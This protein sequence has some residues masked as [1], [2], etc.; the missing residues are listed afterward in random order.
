MDKNPPQLDSFQCVSTAL[1]SCFFHGKYEQTKDVEQRAWKLK[2][3]VIALACRKTCERQMCS[4]FRQEP[5]QRLS[6]CT[7]IACERHTRVHAEPVTAIRRSW[8]QCWMLVVSTKSFWS[9]CHSNVQY[10]EKNQFSFDSVQ[11]FL[12]SLLPWSQNHSASSSNEAVW[13]GRALL[14]AFGFNDK[15]TRDKVEGACFTHYEGITTTEFHS[16]F[17][18]RLWNRFLTHHSPVSSLLCLCLSLSPSLFLFPPWTTCWKFPSLFLTWMFMAHN[19]LRNI[20]IVQTRVSGSICPMYFMHLLRQTDVSNEHLRAFMLQVIG[21]NK[22]LKRAWIAVCVDCAE[23]HVPFLSTWVEHKR[24]R[25]NAE[26]SVHRTEKNYHTRKLVWC[27]SLE[28][29][30]KCTAHEM[31][32]LKFWLTDCAVAAQG[33]GACCLRH[34]QAWLSHLPDCHSL[35]LVAWFSTVKFKMLK[36]KTEVPCYRATH[37]PLICQSICGRQGKTNEPFPLFSLSSIPCLFSA[38]SGSYF[39]E[40][41]NLALDQCLSAA[42]PC[43]RR[44]MCCWSVLNLRCC[45]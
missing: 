8:R 40:G 26:R 11:Q 32:G 2:L 19:S 42:E 3:R 10:S 39:R 31:V 12:S 17:G 35:C 28:K 9:C 23:L 44:H 38:V 37:C 25:W 30:F 4:Q 7:V 15:K 18:A 33:N 21:Y 5:A 45:C 36:N 27:G 43:S 29:I 16:I 20:F 6:R 14:F 41:L 34:C 22:G 24:R 1:A 13:E